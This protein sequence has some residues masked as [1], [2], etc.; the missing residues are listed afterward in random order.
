MAVALLLCGCIRPTAAIVAASSEPQLVACS[1]TSDAALSASDASP[2]TFDAPLDSSD[3]AS[4]KEES[5]PAGT[6]RLAC[7]AMAFLAS[8]LVLTRDKRCRTKHFSPI[9]CPVQP[10]ILHRLVAAEAAR[11]IVIQAQ[12]H[13]RL[14]RIIAAEASIL[15]AA[16]VISSRQR[17]LSPAAHMCLTRGW[18]FHH[19]LPR[20][21]CG[22]GVC[23]GNA[24]VP[25]VPRPL[26]QSTSV[27]APIS[28]A[29]VA[30]VVSAPTSPTTGAFTSPVAISADVASPIVA[31]ADGVY[32]HQSPRSPTGYEGI[33]FSPKRRGRKQYRAR[34]RGELIGY[35]ST[36]VEAAVH[37]ARR[38][39]TAT[40]RSLSTPAA[41][42]DLAAEVTLPSNGETLRLHLS[43]TSSTGYRGVDHL[44][45]RGLAK[46]YRARL[47]PSAADFVG[48][49]D[50]ALGAAIAYAIA[51]REREDLVLFWA[52]SDLEFLSGLAS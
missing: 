17:H 6:L 51:H 47:G 36:A 41:R 7:L 19:L 46:P 12:L 8:I 27:A 15:A 38:V 45:S 31:W 40:P 13:V 18:G 37:Y 26:P 5:R 39:A 32:L 44:S 29:F 33:S 28:R 22:P 35:Y 2:N 21:V 25:H 4:A 23:V 50:S 48:Y 42:L 52:Q 3:R 20:R 9:C 24:S 30:R 49:Y 1:A 14:H 11:A 43:S 16:T 10:S 34:F